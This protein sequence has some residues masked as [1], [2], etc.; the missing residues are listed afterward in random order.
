MLK[1][2][3]PTDSSTIWQSLIDAADDDKADK[4]VGTKIN[5]LNSSAL[6]KFTRPVI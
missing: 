3:I 4:S 2:I 6:K 5:L 1:T